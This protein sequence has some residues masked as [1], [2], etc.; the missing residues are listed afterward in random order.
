[1]TTTQGIK[2]DEPTRKRLKVLAAV[3]NRTAHWLMRTAIQDYLAREEKYERE[4]REDM[5]E[6]ERYKLDG[7]FVSHK[8]VE[9]WLSSLAQGRTK[10]RP[11]K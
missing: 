3:R 8:S 4:K 7:K 6:W 10:K 2:L 1:L 5:E 11:K 9:K